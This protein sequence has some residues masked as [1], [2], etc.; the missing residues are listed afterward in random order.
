LGAT[1][2]TTKDR[3][4]QELDEEADKEEQAKAE[5]FDE[6]IQ[7]TWKLKLLLKRSC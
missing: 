3:E 7:I 6:T 5:K 4:I 2:A 1:A